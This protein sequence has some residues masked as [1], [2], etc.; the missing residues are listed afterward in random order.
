MAETWAVLTAHLREIE[1]SHWR[2]LPELTNENAAYCSG[3]CRTQAW[4]MSTVL[5]VNFFFFCCLLKIRLWTITLTNT[6]NIIFWNCRCCTTWTNCLRR[7]KW[8]HYFKTHELHIF[9]VE[10]SRYFNS[11]FFVCSIESNIVENK[12]YINC[13]FLYLFR[14]RGILLEYSRIV[15]K[16]IIMMHILLIE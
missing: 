1:T 6:M 11:I 4:S 2:G 14:L 8:C 13:Y 12:C 3:S 5:E 16:Q 7:N 15:L 9:H 10:T